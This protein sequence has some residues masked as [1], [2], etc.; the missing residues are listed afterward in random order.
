[1]CLSS[2]CAFVVRTRVLKKV[3]LYVFNQRWELNDLLTRPTKMPSF[4]SIILFVELSNSQYFGIFG[5]L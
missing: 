2:D 3:I 5:C 1:M 4:V